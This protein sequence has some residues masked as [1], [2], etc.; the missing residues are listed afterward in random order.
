MRKPKL[1]EAVCVAPVACKHCSSLYDIPQNSTV[2]RS[3]RRAQVN[4]NR[5]VIRGSIRLIA[6]RPPPSMSTKARAEAIGRAHARALSGEMLL[7]EALRQ[8][9]VIF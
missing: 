3:C 7:T 4:R 2:C 1:F 8:E 9:G 6:R 5:S